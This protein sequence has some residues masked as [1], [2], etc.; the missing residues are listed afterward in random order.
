MASRRPKILMVADRPDWAYD[1][2]A[3]FVI[4][5]L[6][7]K[8]DFYM[9]Y[10]LYNRKERRHG[11]RA[12][13][14]GKRNQL[15]HF[16]R[17]RIL[18]PGEKYDLICFLA[19]SFL[20][21]GNFDISGEAIIQGIFTDGFPPQCY[22]LISNSE[23]NIREFA[24]K[25]LGMA[26]FVLAGSKAIY[27][28]YRPFVKNLYYATGAIDTDLFAPI[29]PVEKD[30][31]SFVVGWTGK[32]SRPFKGFYDFVV[33]AVRQAAS[34]RPGISLKT[35]FRGPLRTLPRF[36]DDVDLLVI[37]SIADAGPFSFLEAGACGVPAISTRIGFPAEVI[38]HGENGMF[39]DR[40]VD[41]MASLI[42]YLYDH[43]DLLERMRKNIRR[44]IEEQWG[45]KARSK[46]W[47]H[48]FEESLHRASGSVTLKL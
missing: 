19:Y 30:G 41:S 42:L 13:I 36:Y 45:Y 32:P 26:T 39:V 17:R 14:R 29:D 20:W 10:L 34:L 38:R 46:L 35:R 28:R 15:K 4:S 1:H 12:R 22:S 16:R 31:A 27:D 40:S 24:D 5:E 43:R 33:P 18:Q 21:R 8:Y 7:E 3:Q 23:I 48:V 37:A 47:D 2:I 44:D 6:G 9:D 11:I 25:Y